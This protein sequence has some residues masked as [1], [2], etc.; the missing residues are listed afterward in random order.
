LVSPSLGGKLFDES[1]GGK[2]TEVIDV[3]THMLSRE[4]FELLRA[5]GAPRYQVKPSKDV[6]APLGIYADGAPFMTPQEGHFDYEM[7]IKRMN[8]AK[9]DLAI[10]SLTA[11]NCFWGGPKTSLRAAQ[12]VNDDMARAQ[13]AWPDRIRW[14]CSIP[15][16]HAELALAELERAT[17]AGAIGVMVLANIAGHSLTDARFAQ[18]WKAIDKK[19]LP[20]LVHPTNPPGTKELDVQ[21]FNLIAQVGFMFDTSLAIARLLYAG[22]LDTYPN[23]TLIAAHA[24]GTLPYLVGRMDICFEN[25]VAVRE[26]VHER[27]SELLRRIGYD[28]VTFTRDALAM[29]VE[30]G[31]A[32]NVMYGSDY[33][34]NIGDMRGCLARVDTLPHGQRLAIRGRNARRMFRL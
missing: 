3:H 22:F 31:G 28:T 9:V 29:C 30:V 11:P 34:H 14:F 1:T 33:P 6:P 27:P 24:G 20:V 12:L 15:W 10:V 32:E 2:M 4:W 13:T 18:I 17:A 5:K 23:V 21:R 8:E 25:M 7:R 19:R 26:K 16:E